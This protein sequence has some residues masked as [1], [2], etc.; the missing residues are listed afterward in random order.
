MAL[1]K[2]LIRTLQERDQHC[3]HCGIEGETLVPHHRRGRGMGGSKLLDI[4]ENLILVCSRWNQ[5]MESD[6]GVM[7]KASGWGHRLSF[8]DSFDKPVFDLSSMSWWTLLPD[9]TKVRIVISD[10][11]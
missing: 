5:D 10:T 6:I 11:F 3:W 2:K 7:S 8:G 4:P 9:G 1:P